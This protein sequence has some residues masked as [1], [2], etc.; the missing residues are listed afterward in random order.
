MT[1]YLMGNNDRGMTVVKV[2]E[3][4]KKEKKPVESE[5]KID[6]VQEKSKKKKHSKK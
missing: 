4:I 5:I 2:I 6:K 3:D 1:S